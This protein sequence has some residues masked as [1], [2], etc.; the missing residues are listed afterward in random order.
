MGIGIGLV[1]LGRRESLLFAWLPGGEAVL[2]LG[3]SKG[4]DRDFSCRRQHGRPVGGFG[5]VAGQNSRVFGRNAT[6]GISVFRSASR[7]SGTTGRRAVNRPSWGRAAVVVWSF[8]RSLFFFCYSCRSESKCGLAGLI[9]IAGAACETRVLGESGCI[10]AVG[11]QEMA[12]DSSLTT[13]T[14]MT[15]ES[16]SKPRKEPV[17]VQWR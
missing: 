8:F 3:Q 15:P 2:V 17:P 5:G 14:L 13:L 1:E 11:R 12:I 4:T 7:F 6:S 16:S 9:A 10:C